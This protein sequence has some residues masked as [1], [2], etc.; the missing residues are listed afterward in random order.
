VTSWL[1]TLRDER[2]QARRAEREAT[3]GSRVESEEREPA[4]QPQVPP[5]LGS[6][7]DGVE[8]TGAS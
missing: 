3:S 7:E 1:K 6:S 4:G 5:R 2:K 8:A